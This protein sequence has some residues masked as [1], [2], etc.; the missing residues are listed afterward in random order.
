MS[1]DGRSGMP[2]ALPAKP[3]E[4]KPARKEAESNAPLPTEEHDGEAVAAPEP[5]PSGPVNIVSRETES[6]GGDAGEPTDAPGLGSPAAAAKKTEHDFSIVGLGASAGGLEALK[7]FFKSIGS[8]TG[9]A[10]VVVQHLDPN[11]ESM[12]ASLL[13]RYT[14]ME[15]REARDATPLKANEVYLIPPGKFIRVVDGGLF[16]DA[17]VQ[18]R[19]MRMPIDHFFRSL[20]EARG[21]Q[22][23]G[24]VLSGTGSDGSQGIREIKAAGGLTI[25]QQPDSA[26]YDGMPRNALATGMVDLSLTIEEMPEAINQYLRNPQ[27][28]QKYTEEAL[29]ETAPDDFQQILRVLKSQTNYDFR[30]YKVGTLNRRIQR[31]M[32]LLRHKDVSDYLAQLRKD[33]REVQ[34]LF[35]DFLISVT[36]FFRDRESWIVLQEEV[37]PGLVER[38]RAGGAIRVWVP[39]CATGEEAYSVAILL[40]E[41]VDKQR[42][43]LDVQVFGTDL[44]ADAIAYAREGLYPEAIAQDVSPERLRR[45]FIEESGKFRVIKRLRQMTVFAVQN[46]ISDPPFSNLDLISCRNL[47]IYLDSDIQSRLVE[48]LH[49]ALNPEGFLFLGSSETLGKYTHLFSALSTSHRIF[50]RVARPRKQGEPRFPIQPRGSRS[51]EPRPKGTKTEGLEHNAWATGVRRAIMQ[52]MVPP[53]VVIDR[54]QEVVFVHGLVRPF[55]S[56]PEGEPRQDLLLMV[57]E[58]VRSKLRASINR[59]IDSGEAATAIL[60]GMGRNGDAHDVRVDISTLDMGNRGEALFLVSFKLIPEQQQAGIPERKSGGPPPSDEEKSRLSQLEYELTATREDLQS[61]IEELESSNEELKASNEEVMSMNEE[62]QSTNEELET[63][64]EELQSLNEELSTVNNQLEDKVSELEATNNDLKNLL[65]STDVATIFLDTKFR[66]RRYTPSSKRVF[67]VLESDIG[68]P[69]S[70]LALRVDDNRLLDHAR[71]VLDRLQPQE[72]DVKAGDGRSYLRR[73]L[74]YRTAE[75]KIDGV[76]VTYSEVTNL[77]KTA[78]LLRRRQ[79]QAAAVAELG[80]MAT[81]A[82]T[83]ISALLDKSVGKIAALLD[84]EFAKVLELSPDGRHLVL[85]S[86][87]GWTEATV[88]KALVPVTPSSQA[89]FTLR[90]GGPIVVSDLKTEKRFSG[91]KLLTDHGVRSGISLIIGP[92]EKPWGI[93]GAHSGEPHNFSADDVNFMQAVANVIG[94]TITRQAIERAHRETAERLQIAINVARLASWEWNMEAGVTTWS[95][96]HYTLL[97]YEPNSV[98]PGWE[99]WH[100][101]LHPE[102]AAR[103]EEAVKE[104]R[105]GTGEFWCEYRVCPSPGVERWLEARGKF[106]YNMN[107]KPIRMF[108]I[109]IDIQERK[110]SEKAQQELLRELDHRV[111]NILAKVTALAS[112][113]RWGAKT[114]DEYVA[115]FTG[116]IQAIASAHTLLS[117]SR[118]TGAE[119]AALLHEELDAYY[120]QDTKNIVLSGPRVT[121]K[122]DDAQLLAIAFHELATNAAKYGALQAEH[123]R[124][125]VSWR[126]DAP[127]ENKEEQFILEWRETGVSQV[128]APQSTGFGTTVLTRLV[129]AQLGGDLCIEYRESGLYCRLQVP[130][131]H[132]LVANGESDRVDWAVEHSASVPEDALAGAR[133][134]ILEDSSLMASEIRDICRSAGAHAI[135]L[136]ASI[137]EATMVLNQYDINVAVLDRNLKGSFSDKIAFRLQAEAKPFLFLTGYGDGN[138]PAPLH[139]SLVLAKPITAPKLVSALMRLLGKAE[140]VG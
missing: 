56:I 68:R 44:D 20:A 64:R 39:G 129:P 32:H 25:V 22:A 130:S 75:N 112:Q 107:G 36:R 135:H 138:L 41:E 113:T 111:K 90:A 67:H 105:D 123:G 54:H 29:E 116:R 88:G 124:L 119:L 53:A 102:D 33:S 108:G 94:E 104:A 31:R 43:T 51:P 122:A 79:Q 101:R 100:A 127:G 118:W 70:D 61:T 78:E 19:G 1:D 134:L 86:G 103:V 62:L 132:V 128:A 58:A 66:I 139:S 133:L 38:T 82:E 18:R 15:V 98:S 72:A 17:P 117:T 93:L 26:E 6:H 87:V 121:L 73:V 28:T 11:H 92:V 12:M 30:C 84:V 50:R 7:R 34:A 35:K 83:D 37:I 2:P 49:F 23:I 48:L 46:I 47:L 120:N 106:L 10:F 131:S 21:E 71:E 3:D 91:A 65:A 89:G 77:K 125:E 140:T 24:V 57:P 8:N 110:E 4:K 85:R 95:E 27:M 55:L 52:A 97:G 13:S 16:L 81:A 96:G 59:V 14:E 74:P 5:A 69:V 136:A 42:K 9:L 80:R 76:V 114:V 99:A 40:A 115:D 60:E 45:F 137:A 63:S 126:L 109:L